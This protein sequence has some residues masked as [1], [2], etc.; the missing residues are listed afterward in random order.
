MRAAAPGAR[1]GQSFRI[2]YGG[3]QA[4]VP[5]NSVKDIVKVAGVVAVQPD[6]LRQPLTDSSSDFVNATGLQNT[7]GGAN[8]PKDAGKGIIFGNLDTGVW[9]EHPSFA[10]QGNLSSPPG[11]ARECNFGDNPLTPANDPFAC[12]NKLIGGAPFLDTYLSNP[13]RAAAEPFH[14]A[15]DSN[16]HGT[17]TS[18]TSAG[19]VVVE[20]AGLRRPTRP[21]PRPR[22]RGLGRRVQGVRHP[23][24]LRLRLR[25]GGRSRRS[26]TAST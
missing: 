6:G 16:G 11:T 21:G 5:A 15:R 14:T 24:L 3:V 10:D 12:N 25:R 4:T 8:G 13:A 1:I 26:S 17:H 23:G 2:V 19:N 18:S 22:A 7:L 9:P 20:R